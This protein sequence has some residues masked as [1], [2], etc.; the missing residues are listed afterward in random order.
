MLTLGSCLSQEE[1][2]EREHHGR[3]YRNK[4]HSDAQMQLCAALI[5]LHLAKA[6]H[7]C[8]WALSKLWITPSPAVSCQRFDRLCYRSFVA[9]CH[10]FFAGERTISLP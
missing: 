10:G 9:V 5:V 8:F 4:N 7:Q 6:W 1:D 2:P 3:C